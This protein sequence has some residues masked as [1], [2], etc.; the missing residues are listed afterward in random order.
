MLKASPYAMIMVTSLASIVR[1][2]LKEQ[3]ANQEFTHVATSEEN[4]FIEAYH[5]LIE[6]TIEQ[7]YEFESIYE[8]GRVLNRWKQFY[9]EN[10]LHGSL[11]NRKPMLV[12]NEH[13]QPVE[14]PR[15]PSAAKLEE[16]SRPAIVGKEAPAIAA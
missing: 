5:S 15:P 7:Q 1:E 12:W 8:A 6:S 2:Y 16:K 11:G 9:N 10:R 3:G 4:S 13:Y 14:P